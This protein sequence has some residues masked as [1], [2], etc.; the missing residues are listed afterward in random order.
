MAR[1]AGMATSGCLAI[2][3]SA[4][5]ALGAATGEVAMYATDM[6]L[7]VPVSRML[8]IRREATDGS[9]VPQNWGPNWDTELGPNSS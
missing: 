3:R 6:M 8:G 9:W 5:A 2:A 7:R 4:Q 1:V